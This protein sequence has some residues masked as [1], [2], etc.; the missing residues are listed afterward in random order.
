MPDEF[1]KKCWVS[2]SLKHARSANP[3]ELLVFNKF[4]MILMYY[5]AIQFIDEIALI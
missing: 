2:H 4:F 5:L 3:A 1:W